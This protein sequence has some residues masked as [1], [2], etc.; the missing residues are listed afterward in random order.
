MVSGLI[1]GRFYSLIRLYSQ[2]QKVSFFSQFSEE[3]FQFQV[4]KKF[5]EESLFCRVKVGLKLFV[6]QV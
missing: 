6:Q 3:N 2:R 1:F 4:G 5:K